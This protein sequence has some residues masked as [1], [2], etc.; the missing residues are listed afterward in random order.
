MQAKQIKTRAEALYGPL[1]RTALGVVHVVAVTREG[2]GFCVLKIGPHAPKSETDFFV[3][4]LARARASA[5]VVTGSVLRAEP[6]LRYDLPA[7]FRDYRSGACGH[8]QPP[9]LCVLTRRGGLPAQHPVW[10]SWA[11]PLVYTGLDSDVALPDRVQVVR[12]QE[13]SPRGAIQYLR[14]QRGCAAVSVEA[15]PSVSGPLYAPPNAVDELWLSVFE[16]ALDPRARGGRFLDL[17]A[18]GETMRPVGEATEVAE[19]SGRWTFQRWL[20]DRGSTRE[21]GS[22]VLV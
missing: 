3:L 7:G 15:G 9:I 1:P 2:A 10:R 12:V 5:I 19:P 20:R 13:P 21:E 22:A 14:E 18:L 4:Q 8:Q 6:G 16:G 11:R 17:R